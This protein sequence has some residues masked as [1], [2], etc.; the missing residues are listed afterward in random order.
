MQQGDARLFR[1]TRGG[2]AHD[3]L[4]QRQLV[5]RLRQ[6]AKGKP[7]GQLVGNGVFGH[8]LPQQLG[9][10]GGITPATAQYGQRITPALPF[11]VAHQGLQF[12]ARDLCIALAQGQRGFGAAHGQRFRRALAPQLQG[13]S[14]MGIFV[15]QHSDAGGALG[16]A[17]IVFCPCRLQIPARCLGQLTCLQGEF[18][19][20]HRSQ[21][22]LA[23][24]R[25]G[26]QSRSGDGQKQQR[27]DGDANHCG[28]VGEPG[29]KMATLNGQKLSAST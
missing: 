7:G 12:P 9:R 27:D 28:H 8:K 4:G 13:F 17:G 23:L 29:R 21:H 22:V 26:R 15:G 3:F 10:Q 1:E 20:H 25:G 2:F 19:R 5:Q 6:P 18:A 11:A 24:H 16:Q 14:G